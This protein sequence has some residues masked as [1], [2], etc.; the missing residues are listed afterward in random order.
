M[1]FYLHTD[2]NSTNVGLT[3]IVCRPFVSNTI[4]GRLVRKES[5]GPTPLA[6]NANV[7]PETSVQGSTLEPSVV[8]V[9]GAAASVS[10]LAT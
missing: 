1:D 2:R 7:R 8:R 3:A 6:R 5:A 4:G 9:P 10:A